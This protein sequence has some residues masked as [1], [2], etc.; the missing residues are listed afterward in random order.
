MKQSK[1]ESLVEANLNV[2]SGFFIS[3][4]MWVFVVAPLYGF[5]NG[6]MTSLSITAI[7][8]VTSLVRAYIIRR[9]FN[10]GLALAAKGLVQGWYKGR[11]K[12]L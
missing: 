10:N 12:C 6:A 1:L 4:G 3:W 7:F 2:F 11:S 9:W 8:T 5:N